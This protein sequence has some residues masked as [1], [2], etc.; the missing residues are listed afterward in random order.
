MIQRINVTIFNFVNSRRML[1]S[2]YTSVDPVAL[3]LKKGG[4]AEVV[5]KSISTMK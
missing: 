1:F 4:C 3:S 5:R 2:I